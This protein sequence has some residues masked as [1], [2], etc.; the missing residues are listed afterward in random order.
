MSSGWARILG[1]V[2]AAIALCVVSPRTV[3]GQ[4]IDAVPGPSKLEA[5]AVSPSRIDLSWSAASSTQIVE[6]RVYLSDGT[7]IAR[8]PAYRNDYSHTGLQ[9]WTISDPLRASSS[10]ESSRSRRR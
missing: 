10:W 3:V 5:K 8:V 2:G 4:A 9:P 1:F 6:Y 7:R